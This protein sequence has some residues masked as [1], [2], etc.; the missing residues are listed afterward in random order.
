[1]KIRTRVVVALLPSIV[2][3]N[4]TLEAQV[5]DPK[6]DTPFVWQPHASTVETTRG[7]PR[8]KVSQADSKRFRNG[9]HIAVAGC[10]DCNTVIS[11]GGT[12]SITVNAPATATNARATATVGLSRYDRTSSYL[13]STIGADNVLIGAAA[14]GYGDWTGMYDGPGRYRSI[15]PLKVISRQGMSSATFASR[16]S[17]TP[18]DSGM[19]SM[20]NVV[21]M[22]ILD[23]RPAGIDGGGWNVY[24][25]SR[26]LSGSQPVL[27]ALGFISVE[28]SIFSKWS[29]PRLDPYQTNVTGYTENYRPDCGTGYETSNDCSAAIHIVNNGGRYKSGIVFGFDSL[30]VDASKGYAD[31]IAMAPNQALSWY[32]AA[33]NVSWSIASIS[34]RGSHT[35]KLRDD[36]MSISGAALSLEGMSGSRNRT[37][38]LKAGDLNLWSTGATST[39]Q[40]GGNSGADYAIARF[41]DSGSYAGIPFFVQRSTGHVGINQAIAKY[42]L[43]VNG[44]TSS[45]LLKLSETHFS[46]LP[47]CDRD[48]AGTVAHV[49]DA[50]APITTWHQRVT[51]GG[52]ANRAFVT[53]NGSGWFAFSY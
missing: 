5:A 27:N 17:D 53:C 13:A 9:D 51:A 48:H 1:M 38:N 16:L 44:T 49:A 21:N 45:T 40:N 3:F 47:T 10:P 29:S 31:A 19:K 52:G 37:I 12:T 15:A 46:E 34:S 26:L 14:Q 42:A 23:N 20:R 25:E 50:S 11:G 30:R 32:S 43:D 2:C 4:S 6:P 8:I 39:M 35:I 18:S 24:N 33:N 28:D 41:D 36:D 7:S 22:A